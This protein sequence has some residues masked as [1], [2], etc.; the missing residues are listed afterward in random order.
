M[1]RYAELMKK[2]QQEH[3]EAKMLGFAFSDKQLREMMNNWGLDPDSESDREKLSYAGAGAYILKEN[4]P[5]YAQMTRRHKAERRKAIEE[6]FTG[7]GFIYDMF[8]HELNNHEFGYTGDYDDT[9]EALGYTWEQVQADE[10]L[11]HGFEKAMSKI[12]EEAD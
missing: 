4:I 1:N 11:K 5:A 6:D 12:L 7:D 10:K 8:L 3:D 2:Q 9:L